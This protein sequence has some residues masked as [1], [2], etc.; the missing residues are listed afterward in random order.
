PERVSPSMGDRGNVVTVVVGCL[1]PLLAG[2]VCEAL[3]IDCR[4]EV[5][6]R[7]VAGAS[8]EREVEAGDP[9]VVV[10]GDQIA[11][12]QLD[13]I[14]TKPGAPPVV[15][16]A[17]QRAGLVGP[18][19]AAGGM[20]CVG[21]DA[22]GREL[23]DA[24]YL[25]ATGNPASFFSR[26]PNEQRYAYP[27]AAAGLTSRELEVLRCL[28]RGLT[29]PEIAASLHIGTATVRTHVSRIFDKF[30]SRKRR[31]YIGLLVPQSGSGAS[32][33]DNVK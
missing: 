21:G 18:L 8:L 31:E 30:G 13:R 19:L 23:R 10:V 27:P 22:S 16:V 26:N 24:V 6:A 28:S 17:G 4:F 29:N 5:I 2:G 3:G 32:R 1:P 7:D 12:E 14:R 15:V 11:Y 33:T 9:Q 25:A 20:T